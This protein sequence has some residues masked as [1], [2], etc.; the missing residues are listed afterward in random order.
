MTNLKGIDVSSHNGRIDWEKAKPHIDFAII[1]AGFG[2]KNEDT[3]FARNMSECNRLKIPV[4]AYWFSYAYTEEMA[5]NEAKYLCSLLSQYQVQYPVAYDFEYDS[6]TFASKHDVVISTALMNKMATVFLEY[7]AKSGYQPMIY[8]NIDFLNRG[9]SELTNK[10]D[11]WLAQWKVSKPSKSCSIWQY[12]DTAKIDGV[13]GTPD[14]NISYV[15]YA[16]KVQTKI[17]D[18]LRTIIASRLPEKWWN[19]YLSVARDVINGKYGNG[20][21]RKVK[22]KEGGFDPTFVQVIVNY[23]LGQ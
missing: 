7:V 13:P 3:C 8:S 22:L 4:G 21:T 18:N 10:F 2:N 1:R 12:S 16:D 11:L 19:D 23:L 5:L 17:N 15:D 9:F 6:V 20:A 14:V